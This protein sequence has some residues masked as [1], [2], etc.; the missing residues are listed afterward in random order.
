[1]LRVL[2]I[3]SSITARDT[4]VEEPNYSS[5]HSRNCSMLDDADKKEGANAYV[6][7][8]GAYTFGLAEVLDGLA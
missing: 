3:E 8:C 1:M 7:W 6:D 5:E 2:S 4:V